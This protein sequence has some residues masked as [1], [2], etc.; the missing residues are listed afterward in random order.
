MNEI[1]TGIN[2]NVVEETDGTRNVAI[3]FHDLQRMVVITPESARQIAFLL[4]ECADF[5]NPPFEADSE[6]S[7]AVFGPYEPTDD[8]DSDEDEDDDE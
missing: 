8:T 7:R 6:E 4:M 2:I 5:V 1:R 3:H